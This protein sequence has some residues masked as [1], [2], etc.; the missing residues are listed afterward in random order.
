MQG[1][2]CWPSQQRYLYWTPG[3]ES[4]L[5]YKSEIMIVRFFPR[6]LCETRCWDRQPQFTENGSFASALY[7]RSSD[8][9]GKL[10]GL[11]P[12]KLCQKAART[13]SSRTYL[14]PSLKSIGC[15][16]VYFSSI[17]PSQYWFQHKIHIMHSLTI[18]P[19]HP[20]SIHI[21]LYWQ[22]PLAFFVGLPNT[23][24]SGKESDPSSTST[25]GFL[26]GAV[27]AVMTGYDRFHC[28]SASGLSC[29]ST[30]SGRTGLRNPQVSILNQS[31]LVARAEWSI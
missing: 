5:D 31:S 24:G 19:M 12:V 20:Y 18:Q 22:Y 7:L 23:R 29:C 6:A 14:D 1:H 30:T 27:R 13:E 21:K 9:S 15:N 25:Q 3:R 2:A 8:R 4:N 11:E 28:T 17:L 26:G 16:V 10:Q